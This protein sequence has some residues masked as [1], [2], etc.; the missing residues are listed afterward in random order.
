MVILMQSDSTTIQLDTLA[1]VSS[2]IFLIGS[3]IAVIVAIGSLQND[4]KTK[5][6]EFGEPRQR[7]N[8][9]DIKHKISYLE[10]DLQK[11]KDT[12]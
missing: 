5:V 9:C 4:V 8:K 1:V 7:D 10:K 3:I 6:E 11:I 12:L 2:I